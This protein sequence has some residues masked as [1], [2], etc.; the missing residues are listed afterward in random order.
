MTE[1][2]IS[3]TWRDKSIELGCETR[4][5]GPAVLMLPALSSI[6]TRAEM[7]PL[8]DALCATFTTTA[9]DWPG[10][11]DRPRPPV[12]WRPD[13][14][15][16]F[17]RF[18][19]QTSGRPFATIAAG[20]AAGYLIAHAAAHPGSA[21]RLILV[22]P[23]WRGP[24]PTMM[25]GR[26]DA[27]R[28]VADL[29]DLPVIG[30]ALYRL[31]VNRSMIR[32]MVAGHVYAD[33]G[34]LA[35]PRLAEKLAVTHARGARHASFRFVAGALDPMPTR[36]A[37]LAAARALADPTLVLYGAKTPPRSRAEMEMLAKLPGIASRVLP[38]GKLAV[39]EEFPAPVAAAVREF[40]ACR[41]Q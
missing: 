31:N 6:S 1:S 2:R 20:H 40:L 14:L 18:L 41:A 22:A 35:G 17:L 5:R 9:V 27:F 19:L 3:W 32:M 13:A 16:D 11:G 25:G 28:T 39:H 21:G 4:G 29:V 15:R 26:R 30:P 34:W 23:T 12:A 8:A 37:F 24:L 38:D 10:F 36:E 33:S 7:R